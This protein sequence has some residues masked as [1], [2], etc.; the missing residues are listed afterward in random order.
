MKL[1]GIV[2]LDMVM[3]G[4]AFVFFGMDDSEYSGIFV[5]LGA[6]ATLAHVL[7]YKREH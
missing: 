7:D 3:V 1:A 6:M 2:L 4:L 5:A